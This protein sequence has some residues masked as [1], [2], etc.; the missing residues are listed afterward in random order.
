MRR[1]S[2]VNPLIREG[3]RLL[4]LF[5]FLGT[6][7]WSFHTSASSYI[8]SGGKLPWNELESL[9]APVESPTPCCNDNPHLLIGTYYSVKSGL[10]AKLLLN[11][12]GPDPLIASPTLFS[13]SGERFDA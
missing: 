1:F 6:L 7:V 8:P 10:Q 3:L 4:V 2:N 12:K 5:A 13:M 9:P 11:N